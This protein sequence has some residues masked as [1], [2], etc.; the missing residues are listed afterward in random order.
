MVSFAR[1]AA[2]GFTIL[3]SNNWLELLRPAEKMH[4]LERSFMLR[5]VS[6]YLDTAPL[7]QQNLRQPLELQDCSSQRRAHVYS[8]L[9]THEHSYAANDAQVLQT[10]DESRPLVLATI[11][12]SIAHQ[13]VD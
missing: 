12:D 8:R 3:I 13:S 11:G 10:L 9:A 2:I 4:R 6:V 5:K 7:A 1:L